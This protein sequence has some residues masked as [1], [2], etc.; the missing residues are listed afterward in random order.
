MSTVENIEK[1]K[2]KISFSVD[3]ETFEKGM[4]YSYNKNKGSVSIQGFRKGKAPRKL[5]EAQYGKAI[6]YDDAVNF[7]LP[8][9]Y[10]NALKENDIEAVSKPEIDVTSIDE[11][12]VAFTAEV[13]V[14][15]EVKLGEYKGLT[16]TKKDPN[17]TDE[18]IDAELKKEQ[19][20]A[21]RIVDVTDRAVQE[22]DIA[23][24]DFKGYIDDEAF[25]GG[26]GKDF[27][28]EI[29]SHTFIDNFEDQLIG[30]EIGQD[31]VVNVTFPENYGKAELE[32]KPAKFE[33]KVNGI[34]HK[35]LPEL[36]DEFIQDTTECENIKDYRNEICGNLLA[37]NI[38]RIKAEKEEELINKLVDVCE[39]DVPQAMI[40]SDVEMK[41]QEYAYQLQQQGIG[42]DMYLQ[43]MG[44]TMD[45]MKEA[46]KPMSEKHVK[47]RLALE[48][49][50][51]AE[52]IE[53][54]EE[55]IKGEAE[56]VANAY[57]MEVE[58]IMKSEDFTNTVK[59]D[60]LRQK[61][62][63]VVEEAAVEA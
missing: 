47:A 59:A 46:Y 36:T 18:D 8:E 43:Y 40:D 23:N 35:E 45:S 30:A 25:E 5:I 38:K 21:A 34:K 61:A 57:G 62:L 13:W 4:D 28:L 50:A 33:V 58:Q 32:N 42:L 22:G 26:E 12:G 53:V 11:N 3:A 14:K 15:P 16:F 27:D 63:T 51:K 24:I 2:V 1:N 37:E 20:K 48:A 49:V 29:G 54:T 19:E 44:Q 52:N 10:E 6:F 41:I 39:M 55:D 31:V 56:K 60:I 17:P 9:A 7:V